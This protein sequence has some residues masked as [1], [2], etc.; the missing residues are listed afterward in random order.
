MP[1]KTYKTPSFLIKISTVVLF[2][3]FYTQMLYFFIIAQ[4]NE[5][6]KMTINLYDIPYADIHLYYKLDLSSRLISSS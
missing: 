3:N 4:S 2:L 6:Q 1:Q 5:P